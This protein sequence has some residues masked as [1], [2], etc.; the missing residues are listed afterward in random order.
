VGLILATWVS[1]AFLVLFVS[2]IAHL[3]ALNSFRDVVRSHAIW[4]NS[5]VTVIVGAV[6]LAEVF[7]GSL[8]IVS[9]VRIT[10]DDRLFTIFLG[11][12]GGLYC[13]FAVYLLILR[14]MQPVASCGC[15][16]DVIV[17]SVLVWRAAILS[18]GCFLSM[19][20]GEGRVSTD[21]TPSLYVV[22]L[23]V[24]TTFVVLAWA[25]PVALDDP[26]ARPAFRA[27]LPRLS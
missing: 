16:G 3:L 12:A 20:I 27:R 14:R 19:A 2:G 5:L 8:G 15:L 11:I 6:T 22:A 10:G 24:T 4:P 21:W 9:A 26:S 25:A 17:G 1:T 18:G 7:G 23:L 13:L